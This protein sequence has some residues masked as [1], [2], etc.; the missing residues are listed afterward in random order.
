MITTLRSLFPSLGPTD[1][2]A[3]LAATFPSPPHHLAIIPPHPRSFPIQ[4]FLA[5]A[6][7]PTCLLT[8][9]LSVLNPLYY[10]ELNSVHCNYL[11]LAH[12]YISQLLSSE[13]CCYSNASPNES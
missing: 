9:V 3:M 5:D 4:S 11:V 7:S 6:E 13:S 10:Q 8:L 12:M 2:C 1:Q